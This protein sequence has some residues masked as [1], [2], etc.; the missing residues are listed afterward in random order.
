VTLLSIYFPNASSDYNNAINEPVLTF[1]LNAGVLSQSWWLEYY[2]FLDGPYWS[3][4]YEV[5]YYLI[6]AFFIYTKGL[7]RWLLVS[8]ACAAAGPKILALFPCWLVGVAAYKLRK[9]GFSQDA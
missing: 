4:S 6:F 7:S 1:A 8:V 3:L 9:A 2:P 5:M